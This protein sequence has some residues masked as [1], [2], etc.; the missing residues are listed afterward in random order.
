MQRIRALGWKRIIIE[1]IPILLMALTVILDQLTKVYFRELIESQGDIWV[2]DGFFYLTYVVNTG[3]A[4]S[5]LANVSWAQTFFKVLTSVALL[6]FVF[7]Y[8]YACQKKYT[9]LKYALAFM[10]GGTVGNFIDRI[11]VSGVTD[12]LGFIFGSYYFP[13]F[14]LAD[15]FLVVGV[16]M[17]MAHFLFLDDG[18]L[19]K[20]ETETPSAKADDALF[21]NDNVEPLNNEDVELLEQEDGSKRVSDN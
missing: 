13:V 18:A 8:I 20:K 4:W 11:A 6:L 12:F 9:W 2:I 15:S 17:L 1:A 14:N 16:I 5:F 7:F 3:A 10:V 21:E 19:L